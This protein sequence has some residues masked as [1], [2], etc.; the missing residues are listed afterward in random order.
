MLIRLIILLAT[1]AWLVASLPQSRFLWTATKFGPT[2]FDYWMGMVRAVIIDFLPLGIVFLE[3]ELEKAH[4]KKAKR[5]YDRKGDDWKEATDFENWART[6]YPSAEQAIKKQLPLLFGL[7]TLVIAVSYEAYYAEYGT[8]LAIYHSTLLGWNIS[9]IVKTLVHGIYLSIA[10]LVTYT[11]GRLS[12]AMEVHLIFSDIGK[13]LFPARKVKASTSINPVIPRKP[14]VKMESCQ[15]C[16]KMLQVG[17]DGTTKRA[18]NA[19]RRA[20]PNYEEGDF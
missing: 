20:C 1:I 15:Y 6:K 16:D 13:W 14:K 10:A 5:S 12:S 11:F 19:H 7:V 9:G 17:K 18:M 2:T 8:D 4:L 3:S